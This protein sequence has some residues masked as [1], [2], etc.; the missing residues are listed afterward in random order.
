MVSGG[1]RVVERY[2]HHHQVTGLSLA[3]TAGTRKEKMTLKSTIV[4]H[5]GL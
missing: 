3:T 1:R 5:L 2:T 4:Y